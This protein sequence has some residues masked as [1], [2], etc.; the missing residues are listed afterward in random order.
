M[1]FIYKKGDIDMYRPIKGT[2]ERYIINEEGNVIDTKP[3]YMEHM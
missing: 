2:N 1:I 3:Y